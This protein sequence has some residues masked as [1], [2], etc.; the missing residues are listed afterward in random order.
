MSPGTIPT[1]RPLRKLAYSR[2]LAV[3]MV[4]GESR[5]SD[6]REAFGGC[7]PDDGRM[8]CGESRASDEREAFGGCSPDDG[9]DGMRRKPCIR[10]TRSVWRMQPG[11]WGD[12]MRRKPR[13]DALSWGRETVLGTERSIGM[14]SP[15]NPFRRNLCI[16][17]NQEPKTAR[18]ESI[19]QKSLYRPKPR[20]KKRENGIHFAEIFVWT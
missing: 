12:G 20:A 16:D 1:A 13:Q 5:A 8:V 6:E 19:S 9:G 2:G 11:R 7:S 15:W 4:C 18:M 17:L 10:R 14:Q 3:G